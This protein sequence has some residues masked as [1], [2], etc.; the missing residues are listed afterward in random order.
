MVCDGHGL[1]G[2]LVSNYVK[3]FLPST[4]YSFLSNSFQENIEKE[5]IN[6]PKGI[7]PNQFIRGA[8]KKAFLNTNT[9]LISGGIDCYF[10]GTTVVGI[11]KLG[12]KLYS[13][14]VG[15]SRAIICS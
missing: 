7:Q 6:I 9:K 3:K 14:N 10:S 13:A 15:D 11:L 12:S 4:F 8:L 5:I 1:H 2:H